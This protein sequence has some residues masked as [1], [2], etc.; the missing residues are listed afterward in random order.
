M[1][2]HVGEKC[3]KLH[4]T[5]ILSSQRGI[6]PTKIDAKWRQS[7]LICSTPKQGHVQNVSSICQSM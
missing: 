6:T 7:N 3:G 5:F 1:S 2:K 4:I